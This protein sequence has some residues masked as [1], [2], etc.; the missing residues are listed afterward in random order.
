[1][2]KT[3]TKSDCLTNAGITIEEK[4][5]HEWVLKAKGPYLGPLVFTIK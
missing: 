5:V 3:P 1:M 4:I 2:K